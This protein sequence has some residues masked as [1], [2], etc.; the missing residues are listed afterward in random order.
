M[1]LEERSFINVVRWYSDDLLY[2]HEKSRKPSTL[3]TRVA[4][5]LVKKGLIERRN[6]WR[7]VLTERAVKV[8]KE[9]KEIGDK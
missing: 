7:Y 4:K 9:L 2:I 1:S 8:L 3:N 6:G 5:R